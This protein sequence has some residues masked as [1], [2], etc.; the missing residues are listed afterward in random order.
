MVHAPE[1]VQ[2]AMNGRCSLSA[3]N[4]SVD[5]SVVSSCSTRLKRGCSLGRAPLANMGSR[6]THLRWI[7]LRVCRPSDSTASRLSHAPASSCA[8]HQQH[9]R[10]VSD[11]SGMMSVCKMRDHNTVQLTWAS[12]GCKQRCTLALRMLCL[13]QGCSEHAADLHRDTLCCSGKD[14]TAAVMMLAYSLSQ[15][16]EI[17]HDLVLGVQQGN[18]RGSTDLE[19]VKVGCLLEAGHQALVV[20]HLCHHLSPLLDQGTAP[21]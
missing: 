17:W 15:A 20:A 9:I 16:L 18:R 7:A 4:A 5:T 14:G 21:S 12:L 8:Q 19:E 2:D 3:D 13:A 1:Q 10:Y 11:V 6:Y